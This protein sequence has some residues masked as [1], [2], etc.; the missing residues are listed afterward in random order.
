[1]FNR[2]IPDIR[3]LDESVVEGE[4]HVYQTSIAAGGDPVLPSRSKYRYS[5]LRGSLLST[6]IPANIDRIKDIISKEAT[7]RV[8]LTRK[9]RYRY[10]YLALY[11]VALGI[12]M[13]I[14]LICGFDFNQRGTELEAL[15]WNQPVCVLYHHCQY[16]F[17]WQSMP[18]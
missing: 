2:I 9:S 16:V 13:F 1:M 5:V 12:S 14:P 8:T 11:S 10:D 17:H 15:Y 7:G 3:I 4:D 18:S 6:R